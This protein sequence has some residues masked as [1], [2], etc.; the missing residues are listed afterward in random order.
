MRLW[1]ELVGLVVG[2]SGQITILI[3]AAMFFID[4]HLPW[5]LLVMIGASMM[6]IGYRMSFRYEVRMLRRSARLKRRKR[7]SLVRAG[8]SELG[9]NSP[10][11]QY[12]EEHQGLG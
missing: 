9:A 6:M 2:Q 5:E 11:I 12:P 7:E 10:S 1:M 3:G 8:S 4:E